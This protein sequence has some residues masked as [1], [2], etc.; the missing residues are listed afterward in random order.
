VDLNVDATPSTRRRGAELESA[1]LD[2]AWQQLV[3]NGWGDFTFESV[4]ARAGTSRP[5]LYRRWADRGE[6]MKAAIQQ[7]GAFTPIEIP[8]TGDLRSDIVIVLQRVSDNRAGFAAVLSVILAGYFR[9]TGTS[10]ADLRDLLRRGPRSGLEV[11]LDH[12]VARGEIDP[13]RLTPRVVEMPMTLARHELLMTLKP[14]PKSVIEEIVD[15]VWLP[16]LR[17]HGA[18]LT[19]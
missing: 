5:V 12:A 6:L 14:L 17:A 13:A 4:A 7:V 2:A 15:E 10:L 8:D 16:L 19:P 1:I 3:Q 9:E 18:L 11:I